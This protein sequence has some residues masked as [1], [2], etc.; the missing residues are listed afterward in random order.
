[1]IHYLHSRKRVSIM[2]PTIPPE[3]YDAVQKFLQ[4]QSPGAVGSGLVSMSDYAL[5]SPEIDRSSERF[6]FD[7]SSEHHSLAY[8][9]IDISRLFCRSVSKESAKYQRCFECK[10]RLNPFLR[11]R[12]CSICN[13]EF[14]SRCVRKI[15][16][17]STAYL[18]KQCLEVM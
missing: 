10:H 14:C 17:V 3:V 5:L 16:A 11:Q 12:S 6:S 18:C 1:M 9:N 13:Q 7:S 15:R 4:T 2:S 8:S